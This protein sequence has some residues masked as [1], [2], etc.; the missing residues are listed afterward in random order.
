[1]RPIPSRHTVGIAFVAGC[2]F[3]SK[4]CA[5]IR[6]PSPRAADVAASLRKNGSVKGVTI[7]LAQA[8]GPQS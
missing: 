2:F 3:S 1:M 8:R 5:Q 7:V 6:A 4:L